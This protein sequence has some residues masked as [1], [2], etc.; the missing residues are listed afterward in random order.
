MVMAMK[1][2]ISAI[3]AVLVVIIVVL[4]MIPPGTD[5]GDD[6]NET[7]DRLDSIPS[8]KQKIYPDMDEL[9][10]VLHND[11]WKSPV[12]LEEPINTASLE[13]SP[14]ITPD[15]QMFF[16]FFTPDIDKEPQ[17]Q[18]IDGVTGIWWCQLINGSWTEPERIIL[19]EDVSLDG[20]EWVSG[21]EMW[22]ASVRVGNYREIDIYTAQLIG[23][24]WTNVENAG[25]LLNENYDIDEF[26]FSPDGNRIY[27]GW[28]CCDPYGDKDIYYLEKENGSWGSP[29]LVEGV[30]SDQ[31]EDQ[32]FITP[33]GNEMWF[34]GQSR[35][36]YPGPSVFRSKWN[37]TGWGEPDEIISQF[38]GEPSLDAEGNIYFVH[39]YFDMTTGIIEADIYVA[40]KI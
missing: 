38:A 14:F 8:T 29:V 16:F 33:D 4:A 12:P 5:E 9:P 26:H 23:D 25:T 39:H 34:T 6:E 18:L 21:D 7:S 10:P 11:S 22:F 15:G 36:G 28:I 35:L 40:Y 24:E 20:A 17:E 19:S 37:G 1:L 30:N 32:P 2:V 27:F 13:D 31:D 3:A